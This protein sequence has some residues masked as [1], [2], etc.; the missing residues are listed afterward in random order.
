VSS[1]WPK[2]D[3]RLGLQAFRVADAMHHPYIGF[4]R[5]LVD[6][7]GIMSAATIKNYLSHVNQ[8]LARRFTEVPPYPRLVTKLLSALESMPR[9]RRFKDPASPQLVASVVG[10]EGLDI[11]VRVAVMLMWHLAVRVGDTVSRSTT[12]YDD[13]Y[14]VLRSDVEFDEDGSMVRITIPRSKSD[15]G[16]S[17]DVYVI[18][19]TGG[20]TCPV[21][22]LRRYWEIGESNGWAGNEPFLRLQSGRLLT[23]A[24]IVA[25]LKQHA[26]VL[27]MNVDHVS[28]H[29]M[30]SGAA[31]QLVT[32]GVSIADIMLVGRWASTE[33]CLKYLRWSRPRVDRVA[34]ALSLEEYVS[35]G[36]VR[37]EV[38]KRGQA[39]AVWWPAQGRGGAGAP[40]TSFRLWE[41]NQAAGSQH[42]FMRSLRPRH[43]RV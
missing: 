43:R 38:G 6:E 13:R 31:T 17:G 9:E 20:I 16:N 30:R 23:R 21:R 25:A 18:G 39:G 32:K 27:G 24:P 29:S 14:T 15:P 19:A 12:Q 36:Q 5:Y 28:A 8:A 42:T 22:F 33:S 10:D 34:Q 40:R 4:I 2:V 37:S 41:V 1:A 3:E 35:P 7:V 11:A 26:Q